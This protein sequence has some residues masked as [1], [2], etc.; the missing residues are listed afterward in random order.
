MLIFIRYYLTIEMFQKA[1]WRNI[2]AN[3]ESKD[4]Y[5]LEEVE[6]SMLWFRIIYN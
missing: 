5:Q 1:I 6:E 2:K 3:A 4:T